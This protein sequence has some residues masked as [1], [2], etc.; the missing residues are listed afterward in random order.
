MFSSCWEIHL[1]DSWEVILSKCWRINNLS[2]TFYRNSFNIWI[3]LNHNFNQGFQWWP[4]TCSLS[5]EISSSLDFILSS[6]SS[7][8]LSLSLSCDL[9]RRTN[10][11]SPVSS[12]PTAINLWHKISEIMWCWWCF[13]L[14]NYPP[15]DVKRTTLNVLILFQ[16]YIYIILLQ[17]YV[18]AGN[19]KKWQSILKM[20][21]VALWSNTHNSLMIS[22]NLNC[23]Q[24]MNWTFDL[25]LAYNKLIKSA[26]QFKVSYFKVWYKIKAIWNYQSTYVDISLT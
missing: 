17:E 21:D 12:L 4:Q 10:S 20:F 2:C 22:K 9:S 18:L 16:M 14:S 7:K 25:T 24:Q 1:D 11:W 6:Q 5:L 26:Y 3:I 23:W 15:I 13:V 8:L 19:C